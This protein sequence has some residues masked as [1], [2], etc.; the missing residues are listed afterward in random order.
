LPIG[1][2]IIGRRFGE[3]TV[4]QAAHFYEQSAGKVIDDYEGGAVI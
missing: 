3:A 1:M 4:L 2:Q